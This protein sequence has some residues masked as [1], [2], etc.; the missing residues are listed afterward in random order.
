MTHIHQRWQEMTCVHPSIQRYTH[1]H[2]HTPKHIQTHPSTSKHHHPST[3]IQA[4][5]FLTNSLF[6]S[7]FG[8]LRLA[9]GTMDEVDP[10]AERRVMEQRQWW[11]VIMESVSRTFL[12]G[13]FGAMA[14]MSFARSH[15][16]DLTP[17]EA[18]RRKARIYG[19]PSLPTAWALACMCFAGVVETT[20]L[21][22]PMTPILTFLYKGQLAG[23]DVFVV[24]E[25]AAAT[26]TKAAT[27][28]SIAIGDRKEETEPIDNPY[29]YVPYV[30]TVGDYAIGGAGAGAIFRGMHVRSLQS[31]A[32]VVAPKI[33]A[34]LG[35]GLAL[36]VIAGCSVCVSTYVDVLMANERIRED[37]RKLQQQEEQKETATAAAAATR[38][39]ETK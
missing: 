25:A 14:G 33:L 24:V 28:R 38:T 17:L 1:T 10:E 6:F 32:P 18:A 36:G 27:N 35:P 30:K 16:V 11:Y 3:T 19:D 8:Q 22:S 13:F 5:L 7:R 12:S 29:W 23:E 34:G 37:N 39:Q 31:R 20:Q 4:S 9:L 2:T 21:V 15:V 26:T